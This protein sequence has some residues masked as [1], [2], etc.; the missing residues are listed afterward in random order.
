MLA[1]AL[2]AAREIAVF[3]DVERVPAGE[4]VDACD[5]DG[6]LDAGVPAAPLAESNDAIDS[7]AGEDCDGPPGHLLFIIKIICN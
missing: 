2:A 3:V 4:R 5:G 7:V 6:D 1:R